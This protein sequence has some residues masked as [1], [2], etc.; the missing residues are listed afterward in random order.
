MEHKLQPTSPSILPNLPDY[1]P[2][3]QAP[4]AAHQLDL[5]TML[6]PNYNPTAYDQTFTQQSAASPSNPP[7]KHK[8]KAAATGR[9]KKTASRPR[10]AFQTRSDN[11]IL[12]D[13][14][15][16][17]KYGQKAVKNSVHPRSYY[18]CTHHTCGVKKQVQRLSTDRSVVETTYEGVHNHPSEKLMEALNPLLKQIQ[19]LTQFN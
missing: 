1:Y 3:A 5:S 13:G 17:R 12:D 4:P 6:F 15:R 9:R 7:P 16:W 2:S 10:F 14:Y 11:D 8:T 19:L 18:R